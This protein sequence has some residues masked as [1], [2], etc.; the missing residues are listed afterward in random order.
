MGLLKFK[1][2]VHPYDG[3]EFSRN[4]P[5]RDLMPGSE[6]AF[7]LSQHIGAPAKPCV[8]V[9]DH[10]LAGQ[11][12]ADA[13]GFVSAAIHSSVS[14]T[15]KAFEKRKNATGDMVDA[16][17][18]E[19]DGQY[20]KAVSSP[21]R[22]LD[23][24]DKKEILRRITDAGVVGM[25]GAGFPTAV[26]LQPKEPDRLD[27]I[28][29]NG[30]ECEPYL[31]SDY[32]I[33]VEHPELVVGGLRCMLK[34]FD[35]AVGWICI[36]SNKPEAVKAMRKAA[37]NE[38]RMEVKVMKTKYPEG[39]ERCLIYAATGREINSKMLPADAG[40]VVDNI[41]TV[42]AVYRAVMLGEPLTERIFTVTGDAVRDPQNIRVKVGTPYSEIVDAAGGFL[43]EPEKMISGGPMMGFAIYD[44]NVPVTKTSGAITCFLKDP[45]SKHDET[46]CINCGRCLHGCPEHLMPCKLADYAEHGDAENFEK[47]NG[48]ECV[49]CGSCSFQCPAKRPLAA[50]I[51]SMR[52]TVMADKRKKG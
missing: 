45:V 16:V 26:K 3:K 13:G 29:V 42:V 9:G 36:E 41:D 50:E 47:Y 27:H 20:T 12:I 34:L 15:V 11:K 5:I 2:G 10:V 30:S 23:D 28:L 14:G 1:G 52:R 7:L 24:A 40:C 31:T 17:I 18:I 49:E 51:K 8:A 21:L 33:M 38:P 35:N 48:L 25:G 32:R 44:L 39:A 6:L 37:E 46:A 19:N 22:S 43:S 4:K